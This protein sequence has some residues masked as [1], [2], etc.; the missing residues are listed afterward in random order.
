MV[1]LL[2]SLTLSAAINTPYQAI[3]SSSTGLLSTGSIDSPTSESRLS[4]SPTFDTVVPNSSD[5]SLAPSL[6][7]AKSSSSIN[8]RFIGNSLAEYQADIRN[9][10]YQIPP[11]VLLNRDGMLPGGGF[12]LGGANYN[13]N[14]GGQG[15]EIM[16]SAQE[17]YNAMQVCDNLCPAPANFIYL[18]T[19]WKTGR[20]HSAPKRNGERGNVALDSST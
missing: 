8:E 1:F 2:V 6:A 16:F 14:I 17:I 15:L 3:G 20:V 13:P 19:K 5:A 11:Y 9:A 10:N 12:G 4:G 7:V 18:L